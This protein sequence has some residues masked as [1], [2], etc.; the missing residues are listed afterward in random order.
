MLNTAQNPSRERP[1][2]LFSRGKFIA[3]LRESNFGTLN[4]W[5]PKWNVT[6]GILSSL[7]AQSNAI[8]EIKVS[9][10]LWYFVYLSGS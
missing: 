9:L 6:A 2:F 7:S 5:E 1:N 10:V 4:G 8:W 3:N